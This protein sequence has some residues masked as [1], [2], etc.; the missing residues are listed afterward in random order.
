[1]VPF[2][3]PRSPANF[4]LLIALLRAEPQGNSIQFMVY[5]HR[6]DTIKG[7]FCILVSYHLLD[8]L[9]YTITCTSD[10]SLIDDAFT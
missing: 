1:M 7:R 5:Y 3:T 6:W 4:D 9:H 10:K 2:P 8:T